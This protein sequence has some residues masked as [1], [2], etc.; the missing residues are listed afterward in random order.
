MPDWAA[1]RK[2]PP[3]PRWRIRPDDA[4][5]GAAPHPWR[6]PGQEVLKW[7]NLV[8]AVTRRLRRRVLVV[9]VPLPPGTAI[10]N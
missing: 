1:R 8:Y 6:V 7:Q 9:A 2:L 10:G 5:A 4:P 3:Q